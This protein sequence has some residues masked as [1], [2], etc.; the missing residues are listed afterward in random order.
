MHGRAAHANES[1]SFQIDAEEQ[2]HTSAADWAIT[3]VIAIAATASTT[4]RA[5]TITD[6]LVFNAVNQSQWTTGDA[7][8][9]STD[10]GRFLGVPGFNEGNSI[11]RIRELCPPIGPCARFGAKLGLTVSGRAG[12]NYDV[13]INS[14][15]V[16]VTLPQVVIYS[17]PDALAIKQGGAFDIVSTL[18]PTTTLTIFS[19]RLNINGHSNNTVVR[20]FMQTTGPT[21]EAL[22]GME[23][24]A[25]IEAIAQ[26]CVVTCIG[27]SLN[28]GVDQTQEL[29]ALNHNGDR[30]LRV[31]GEPVVSA[32][33]RQ[34][35]G[36]GSLIVTAQLP[37]LNTDSRRQ[38]NGFSGGLLQSDTRSNIV[39]LVANL[40]KIVSDVIGLPRLNGSSNGF[41][42]NLLTATAGLNIDVAQSF[43]FDPNL[44]TT[45]NF[46]SPVQTRDA[47]G[48]NAPTNSV[49]FRVGDTVRLRA[50]FALNL[51]IA[52]EYTLDNQL[53]N[54]TSLQVDGDVHVTAGGADIFGQT[55]GPLVDEMA[56]GGLARIPLYDH[57]F[58]VNARQIRT[59]PFNIAFA[60]G[61]DTAMA[62]NCLAVDPAA[63]DRSGLFSFNPPVCFGS[64]ANCLPTQPNLP[65]QIYLLADI[66]SQLDTSPDGNDCVRFDAQGRP[67]NTN[68]ATQTLIPELIALADTLHLG[69]T[70]EFVFEDNGNRVFLNSSVDPFLNDLLHTVSMDTDED[71]M[72]RLTALGFTDAPPVFTIAS[73]L[74]FPT[75]L[76]APSAAYLLLFV[77]LGM[78]RWKR[79]T[80]GWPRPQHGK[81]SMAT[82]AWQ[83]RLL[84]QTGADYSPSRSARRLGNWSFDQILRVKRGF[85]D[86]MSI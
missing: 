47:G 78:A 60:F 45:L 68:F 35:V 11:G 3:L 8:A 14:G 41:G 36:D 58:L 2:L 63:C 80:A 50:P 22:V 18:V 69:E 66:Y 42:Y 43:T 15:S 39:A 33:T 7:L 83:R 52:P 56:A 53:R 6:K 77:M 79:F 61:S 20:P 44:L 64:L 23:V 51:G 81:G 13:K 25:N 71:A 86:D 67:C 55:L 30:Q 82:A 16:S 10:G 54:Q 72:R 27:P 32:E 85:F 34:T 21:A 73:G 62:D 76:P 17:V 84:R 57:S 24:K 26:A 9:F 29:L 38:S 70:S 28:E 4:A 74:P 46:T 37:R 75:S 1:E 59:D 48:F 5:A 40:D 49:T 65:N 19:D 31:L 12:L